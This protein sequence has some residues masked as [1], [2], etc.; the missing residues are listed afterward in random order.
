MSDYW[1]DNN[2]TKPLSFVVCAACRYNNVIILGARHW[3]ERMRQQY[4]MMMYCPKWDN[5]GTVP[6]P[7]EFEEGFINQFGEFLT[8]SEAM[9]AAKTNGQYV[10][11]ERGCGGDSELLYSEGLY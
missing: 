10:D 5:M 2:I 9:I 7:Y 3:D 4:E 11:I 6:R 1:I 8:R